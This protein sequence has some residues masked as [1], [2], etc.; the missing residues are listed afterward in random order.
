MWAWVD[1][2]SGVMADAGVA[3]TLL[4]ALVALVMIGTRQPA[5][6]V[7]LAR[8]TMV[9][10]I[11]LGPLVGLGLV[12]RLDLIAQARQFG[13]FTL[14]SLS[15][16]PRPE[17]VLGITAPDAPAA[18]TR[19]V[20][21]PLGPWFARALT[22][23]YLGGVGCGIAWLLLGHVGLVLL[24]RR[25][26]EPS[27][28]ALA[29]HQA[30]AI[31]PGSRRPRLRVAARVR[32]PVLLGFPWWLI[33]IPPELDPAGSGS[34]GSE[35][36]ADSGSLLH[37]GLLHELAHAEAGDA[38]FALPTRL[39]QAL[40]FALPPLWWI[41]AQMRLD[42]EFLA[43]RRAALR[44]GLLAEYAAALLE[45]ASTRTSAPHL[46]ARPLSR[47]LHDDSLA[48]HSALFQRILMLLR[49]PFP[50]EAAP[51]AWWAR[52]LSCLAVLVTLGISC[53]SL[54]STP[55]AA[56]PPAGVAPR[57]FRM[58]RLE[59]PARPPV[60]QGRAPLFGL[61]IRMPGQFDLTVEVWAD[62]PALS[63]TRVVGLRLGPEHEAASE[64][65]RVLPPESWHVVHVRRDRGG[66]TL[67]VD[68]QPVPLNSE[69]LGLTTWLSVEPAANRD[70]R[71][72]SLQLLW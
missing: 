38:W 18:A 49:C 41:S 2:L 36:A 72:R 9:G 22:L 6:R 42:Q 53:L 59:V 13:G 44:F 3:A 26:H 31:V 51:P 27:R 16:T 43:D 40:W 37:L 11:A 60:R 17:P 8:A 63:Q 67:R 57:A 19:S 24:A 1:R 58:S 56:P 65:S 10:L 50:V 25:S 7:R 61:P 12:P 28:A 20:A 35:P 14:A 47:P 62:P 64:P 70:G 66:I 45:F 69:P 71:Y 48:E 4:V 30:L 5:R 39:A 33:L 23:T 68:E 55:G 29:A 32:R 21:R 46:P 15:R 34:E 52:G 54:R